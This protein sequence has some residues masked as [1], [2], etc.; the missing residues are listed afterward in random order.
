M[1]SGNGFHLHA[2]PT[3]WLPK[4]HRTS[5]VPIPSQLCNYYFAEK[6]HFGLNLSTTFKNAISLQIENEVRSSKILYN[7]QSVSQSVS[8]CWCRAPLWDLGPDITSCRYVAVFWRG[9]YWGFLQFWFKRCW[10]GCSGRNLVWLW[11][12]ILWRKFLKSEY[13]EGCMRSK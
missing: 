10:S 2:S 6:T 4:S 5:F 9:L 1:S 12:A 3:F 7:L 13:L 11:R 8:M